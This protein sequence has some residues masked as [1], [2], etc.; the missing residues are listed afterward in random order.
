[1]IRRLAGAGLLFACVVLGQDAARPEFEVGTIKLNKSG[2]TE[3]TG[4]ILAGGQISI[5]NVTLSALLQAPYLDQTGLE[6]GYDIKLNW[7]PRTLL[8]KGGLTMFEAVDK[9]LGLKLEGKKLPMS[10]VVV[11]RVGKLAEN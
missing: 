3:Q 4:G 11:D 6:G 2:A 9:M 10:V 1:M 5:R 7:A 8:D